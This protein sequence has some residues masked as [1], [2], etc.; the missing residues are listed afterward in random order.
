MNLNRISD[1]TETIALG[2]LQKYAMTKKGTFRGRQLRL[3]RRTKDLQL[4]GVRWL[5]PHRR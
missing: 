3:R 2:N 4:Q 1:E 5:L